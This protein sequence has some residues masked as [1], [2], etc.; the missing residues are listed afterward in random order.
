MSATVS[1]S[2][3]AILPKD[4][5]NVIGGRDRIG[6]AVR[7]F[8]IDVDQAHLD[9]RER[10][11]EDAVLVAIAREKLGRAPI[12][13]IWLPIVAAP[14]SEAECLEAHGFQSHVAGQNHEVAPGELLTVFFL[15]RP[16]EPARLVEIRVVGPAVERFEALLRAAR[17]AAPVKDAIGARAVPSHADEEWPVISEIGGPPILR[18]RQHR[19]DVIFDGGEV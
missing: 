5:A 2:F 17:A 14:A 8:G 4:L 9:G 12:D 15:H 1:S 18:R 16:Q 10:L 19:L 7:P 11:L 6:I 3:I 13:E